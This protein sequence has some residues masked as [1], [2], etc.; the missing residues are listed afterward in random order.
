MLFINQNLIQYTIHSYSQRETSAV[1]EI[2]YSDELTFKHKLIT[3][4][5][6]NHTEMDYKSFVHIFW[7]EF[8]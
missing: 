3:S 2:K 7:A 8:V 4:V 6:R 1:H 5:S